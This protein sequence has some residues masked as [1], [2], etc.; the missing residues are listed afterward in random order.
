[1]EECDIKLYKNSC[2]VKNPR[3]SRGRYG[4][5]FLSQESISA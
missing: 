2:G 3:D 5:Y 1:M 4:G